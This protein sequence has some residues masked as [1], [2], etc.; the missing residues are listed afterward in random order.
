MPVGGRGSTLTADPVE[1]ELLK[2][3][4]AA[5]MEM[6]EFYFSTSTSFDKLVQDQNRLLRYTLRSVQDVK[7]HHSCIGR[8]GKQREDHI[9][10][11]RARSLSAGRERAAQRIAALD[12]YTNENRKSLEGGELS[13]KDKAV[14]SRERAAMQPNI[15][16]AREVWRGRKQLSSFRDPVL[17]VTTLRPYSA[18]P[19]SR[20]TS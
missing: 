16:S 2:L 15:P 20:R 19:V 17:S 8:I 1:V 13:E 12:A 6:V 10:K 7:Q 14:V 4:V 18:P 3:R 5:R 9:H 11:M